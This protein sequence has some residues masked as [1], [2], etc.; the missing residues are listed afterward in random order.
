[1]ELMLTEHLEESENKLKYSFIG[2]STS[3]FNDDGT[4]YLKLLDG[5]MMEIQYMD[6]LLMIIQKI[7]PVMTLVEE[8]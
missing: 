5:H 1:M 6:L 2:Y 3:P 4:K 8:D 7:L